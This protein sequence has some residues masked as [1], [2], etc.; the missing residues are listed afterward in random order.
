MEKKD[1]I[2]DDYLDLDID[3]QGEECDH[4]SYID[5]DDLYYE[6]WKEKVRERDIIFNE[7]LFEGFDYPLSEEYLAELKN[8]ILPVVSEVL[9]PIQLLALHTFSNRDA[10]LSNCPIERKQFTLNEIANSKNLGDFDIENIDE[11]NHKLDK[12]DSVVF[13][14]LTNILCKSEII[15]LLSFKQDYRQEDLIE[16]WNHISK[17]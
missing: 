13:L 9:T 7:N 16:N 11:F 6:L 14:I 8:N 10:K 4:E 17:K 5:I 2:I 3:Y 15:Q 1:F 12:I